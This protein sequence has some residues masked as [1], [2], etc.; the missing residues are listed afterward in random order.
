[1]ALTASRRTDR[2]IPP[3]PIK[4]DVPA[5]WVIN[6]K[7]AKADTANAAK[8]DHSDSFGTMP[9]RKPGCLLA[10]QAEAIKIKGLSNGKNK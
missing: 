3:N 8:A 10:Y 9:G 6:N 7:A 5:P 2:P 4:P 1:M